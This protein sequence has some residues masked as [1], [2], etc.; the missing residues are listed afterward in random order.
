MEVED[1]I[2]CRALSFLATSLIAILGSDADHWYERRNLLCL[3]DLEFFNCRWMERRATV[4]HHR[5]CSPTGES[6]KAGRALG[7]KW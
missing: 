7:L 1:L 2:S 6:K 3:V 5:S 4:S